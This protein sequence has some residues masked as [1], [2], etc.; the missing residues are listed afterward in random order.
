MIRLK[1]LLNEGEIK[2]IGGDQ[3]ELLDAITFVNNG[4]GKGNQKVQLS[5]FDEHTATFDAIR[6][7][8]EDL[9]IN[10]LTPVEA[11]MKLQAI[12]QKLN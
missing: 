8:L 3:D 4:V 12:K 11:L 10:N 2:M 9:D 1:D 7:E 5:I 6:K